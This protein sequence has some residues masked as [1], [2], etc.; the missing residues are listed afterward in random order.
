[1]PVILRGFLVF[2]LI[3]PCLPGVLSLEVQELL[4]MAKVR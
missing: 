1:M 4:E 3:Y 2:M